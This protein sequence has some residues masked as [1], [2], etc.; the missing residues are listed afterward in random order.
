MAG[1]TLR[2]DEFKYAI[3]CALHIEFDA[4]YLAL[5]EEYEAVLGHHDQDRNSYTAGRIG[6]SNVVVVLVEKGNSSG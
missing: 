6:T 2:C 4:V 3:I 1:R 5:D